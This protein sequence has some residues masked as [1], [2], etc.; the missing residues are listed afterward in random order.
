MKIYGIPNCGTV[1]KAKAA[2]AAPV[3]FEAIDFRNDPPNVRWSTWVGAARKQSH[4]QHERRAVSRP[5]RR[6]ENLG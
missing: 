3:A 4:A 6:E 1:K 5:A 2:G